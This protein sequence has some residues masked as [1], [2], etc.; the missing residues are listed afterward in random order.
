ME[1]LIGCPMSEKIHGKMRR[2][3]FRLSHLGV[4]ASDVAFCL[5]QPCLR[6]Q[7][8]VARMDLLLLLRL[9]QISLRRSAK[10]ARLSVTMLELV[11]MKPKNKPN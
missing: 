7:N 6:P 2:G 10:S 8:V 4:E 11:S 5:R 9:S 3:A 1:D